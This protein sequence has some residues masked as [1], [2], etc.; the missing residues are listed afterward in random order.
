MGT[1]P[2]LKQ[3][4]NIPY[5]QLDNA[6]WFCSTGEPS[7][8]QLDWAK[9]HF[10]S[11]GPGYERIVFFKDSLTCPVGWW[12]QGGTECQCCFS[13]V[14]AH[15]EEEHR[16][17]HAGYNGLEWHLSNCEENTSKEAISKLGQGFLT[18]SWSVLWCSVMRQQQY[19]LFLQTMLPLYWA[20]FPVIVRFESRAVRN[21]DINRYLQ[22]TQQEIPYVCCR[23]V[24]SI[25][26]AVYL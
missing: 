11:S 3:P 9:A 16:A 23:V 10:S 2:E 15:L 18:S 7:H 20:G 4:E 12:L 5:Q 21:I 25:V 17:I 8:V 1:G 6:N 13:S 22:C 19:L 26:V 24:E 14:H